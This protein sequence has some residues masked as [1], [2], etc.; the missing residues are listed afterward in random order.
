MFIN[1]EIKSK[2]GLIL[3]RS[4]DDYNIEQV[5]LLPQGSTARPQGPTVY[6]TPHHSERDAMLHIYL[7]L[8]CSPSSL[9][10][11]RNMLLPKIVMQVANK[12][13]H[14]GK[15]TVPCCG[16][17]LKLFKDVL[18]LLMYQNICLSM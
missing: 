4:L 8:S 18:Y 12:Q 13:F 17:L 6:V 1:K 7:F 14:L 5:L 9:S 15:G 11:G 2:K 10:S 16:I 3:R